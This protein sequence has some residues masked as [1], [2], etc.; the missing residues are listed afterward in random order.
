MLNVE[1]KNLVLANAA[2]GIDVDDRKP[3]R[4]GIL[5]VLLGFGG[6]LLW[7]WLAPLD[8]GVVATATVKVTSNRKTIQHLTGGTVDAILVREGDS[9]KKDQELVR[10]DST[11]AISEQG[12][13]SAQ[14]IVSKTVENRLE[15]ERDGVSDITFDPALLE[16][17]K[18]DPR[19]LSSLTLQRRLFLTRLTGLAGEVSILQ[20]TLRSAE[21]QIK[22]LQQIYGARASQLKFLHQE[23]DGARSLAAE[24]YIP[25]NRML[26]LERSAADLN[27][28]QAENFNNIARTRSQVAELKLRILQREYDYRKEVQSQLTDAQKEN[29]ALADRLQALDYQVKHTVIRSPI[30]GMVQ[31]LNISTIGGVIQPGFKIMD[32]VPANEPLQVDAMIPVQAIDKMA[33]GLQVDIAFPAFNHAQ[34]PN[35]PGK[36]LTI[37]ADRLINEENKQPFYLAQIEV[38]PAGMSMLGANQIRAGMPATVT[39]KTGER[40]LMSYL[41]KPL[42]DRL[43]SSFKEQ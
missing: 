36:V 15:A 8:A 30:D 16:R 37:S 38:T 41:M 4:W 31:G 28:S 12:V 20:E 42:I 10:L 26:E 5:L 14:Y 23:L 6:F 27:A 9:V 40:N 34:T 7:S 2:L 1:H 25:R 21:G 17:F 35:I 19:L 39:I 13:V 18:A 43:D 3:A 29:T 33:P 11:Q 24:G 22:G 32:I